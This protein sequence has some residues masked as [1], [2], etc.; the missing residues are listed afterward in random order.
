MSGKSMLILGASGR[1]GI[2]TLKLAL[3]NGHKVTAY[4]RNEAKLREKL[5]TDAEHN[6]LTVRCYLLNEELIVLIPTC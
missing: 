1:S 2:L 3:E 4:V 5:G 6:E